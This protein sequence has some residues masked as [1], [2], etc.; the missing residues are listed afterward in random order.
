MWERGEG[1]VGKDK[2]GLPRLATSQEGVGL[3]GDN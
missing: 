2:A 1:V 3:G